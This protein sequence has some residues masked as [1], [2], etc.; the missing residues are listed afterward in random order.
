MPAATGTDN[1]VCRVA[2]RTLLRTSVRCGRLTLALCHDKMFD[3]D[4]AFA[5]EPVRPAR[6]VAGCENMRDAASPDTH[7][8]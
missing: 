8:P 5:G 7:P 1:H 2:Y 3:P 4:W 6:D